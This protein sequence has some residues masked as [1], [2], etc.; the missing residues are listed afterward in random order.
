[1]RAAPKVPLPVAEKRLDL[2]DEAATSALARRIAGLALPGDVIALRGDLGAGKTF[3][4]RAFIGEADVPSPTFTLVQTYERPPG[5]PGARVWHFD[6]YRLK[7][8]DEA[9]ELDIEDAFAEGI[10]LIEWPER[11]GSLLPEGRLDVELGFGAEAEARTATL[12]GRGRWA[13]LL[14]RLGP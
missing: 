11:L 7:Q 6:L 10:S 13:G 3:F 8:A 14:D 4:A 2:P 9:I 1:M 12:T 5:C